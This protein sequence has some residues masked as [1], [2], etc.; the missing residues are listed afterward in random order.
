MVPG[1]YESQFS[2]L[3]KAGNDNL[4]YMFV[5][6]KCN[7]ACKVFN[8]G[9]D[10]KESSRNGNYW[11]LRPLSYLGKQYFL[12]LT[13]LFLAALGLRCCAWAFSSCDERG[14]LFFVVLGLLIVVASLVAEHGL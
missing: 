3:K 12:Q 11:Y 13:Y 9:P 14:L 1:L 10:T 7:N 8:T 4:P 6:I 5:Q 2:R